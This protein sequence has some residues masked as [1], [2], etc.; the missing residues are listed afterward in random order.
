[1]VKVLYAVGFLLFIT[2]ACG[3]ESDGNLMLIFGAVALV[4]ILMMYLGWR[5]GC[6]RKVKRKAEQYRR[7]SCR[8]ADLHCNHIDIRRNG[9]L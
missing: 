1:M 4:G 6:A 5:C 2:G 3:I 9:S 7:G 8:V